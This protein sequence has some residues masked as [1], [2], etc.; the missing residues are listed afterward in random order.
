MKNG[1]IKT[2][3]K[4][5]GRHT[6]FTLDLCEKAAKVM[7]ETG[8]HKQVRQAL[9]ISAASYFRW[10]ND[11]PEF[12][13]A[14]DQ[15]RLDR[16]RYQN[17]EFMRETKAAFVGLEMLLTGFT[18]TLYDKEVT[19]LRDQATGEL[20][21]ILRVVTKEREVF[22]GPNMRAIE[23]VIGPKDI[24]HN[25]YLKSLESQALDKE[26]ELYKLVFG[27]LLMGEDEE[28]FEGAGVLSDELDLV[29]LRYME[30]VV[31][32]DYDND[33]ITM[34]EWVDYTGNI[35]HQFAKIADRRENRS[36][37]L[38]GADS[39]QE[40]QEQIQRTWGLITATFE[41]VLG[42][43]FKRKNGKKF[44]IPAEIRNEIMDRA[45]MTIRERAGKKQHL[46]RKL[47]RP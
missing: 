30:A 45:V 36:R 33:A 35:R 28:G 9:H 5:S 21:Q 2:A 22:I 16:D 11:I 10:L 47:P 24:R 37:Q 19:E 26:A 6:K 44:T 8:K 32:R 3:I 13:E 14:I 41:E 4:K 29:K 39:Y 18:K 12:K 25:I 7:L 1:S 31:Q 27:E 34:G 20:Q 46:L 17:K 40:I 38:M 23:K 43:S 15:G 42:Y